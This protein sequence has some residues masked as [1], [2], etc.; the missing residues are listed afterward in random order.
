MCIYTL[1]LPVSRINKQNK[2]EVKAYM[3]FGSVIYWVMLVA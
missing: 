2:F 1:I 3:F